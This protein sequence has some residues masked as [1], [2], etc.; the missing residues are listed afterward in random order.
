MAEVEPDLVNINDFLALVSLS[1]TYNP[2]D[3]RPDAPG[4]VDT[5]TATF[6]NISFKQLGHLQFMVQTLS[7]SGYKVLN[8]SGNGRKGSVVL[9]DLGDDKI[10]SP[11]ES[12]T[13]V[14]KI[15]L[16]SEQPFS[17]FVDVFGKDV[18]P[19][20]TVFTNPL[21]PRLLEGKTVNGDAI[22]YAGEKDA[23]GLAMALNSVRIQYSSGD[24]VVTLVDEQSRPTQIQAADGETYKITWQSDTLLLITAISVDGTLQ[25]NWSVD[26]ANGTISEPNVLTSAQSATV[27]TS[28][29]LATVDAHPE[30]SP[31][32]G[33]PV[34]AI[35][36][37]VG[38]TA[39]IQTKSVGPTA[40]IHA[41]TRQ[42]PDPVSTVH[43][44]KCGRPVDDAVVEMTVLG[45]AS[46]SAFSLPVEKTSTPG[47]YSLSL[48]T[49]SHQ[50]SGDQVE[51]VLTKVVNILD[52]ACK[53]KKSL[54]ILFGQ[55]W[56]E[57]LCA[58]LGPGLFPRCAVI[59]AAAQFYCNIL[60][61]SP[62]PGPAPGP[63]SPVAYI[64]S[65]TGEVVDFFLEEELTF[66]PTADIPGVGIRAAPA[67]SALPQGPF[68]TFEID[69]G[70]GFAEI[71]SLTA[72]PKAPAAYQAYTA[73][74]EIACASYGTRIRMEVNGSDRYHSTANCDASADGDV[75]CTLLVPGGAESVRDQVTV[76][77]SALVPYRTENVDLSQTI[78]VIF[79]PYE[80]FP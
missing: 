68:P 76:R 20:F 15:G 63:Q 78:M 33:M 46:P 74:A 70:F 50:T 45:G 53:F 44:S 41:S 12:F 5:I 30:L 40:S 37:S 64:A 1:D 43:V 2:N 6:Q 38:S 24:V 77:V 67:Q 34:Q 25:V 13:Q 23:N 75:E 42:V 49:D 59:V 72:E 4:G 8:A 62:S 73:S 79:G 32:G 60:A 71:I 10:L 69:A 39:S 52:N 57:V 18:S 19:T 58:K 11:G 35:T 31:R 54:D 9:V 36:K 21:D 66:I 65:H 29:K 7:G 22:T 48:P 14:F 28:A 3:I 47:E 16:L 26:L 55:L 51:T 56:P 17:L 61:A 27:S 80:P